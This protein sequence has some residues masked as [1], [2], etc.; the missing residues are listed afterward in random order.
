MLP[1]G[2]EGA[3]RAAAR[4]PATRSRRRRSL[5]LP[6]MPASQPPH[7]SFF[8]VTK[9][10]LLTRTPESECV[11]Y[12]CGHGDAW[13]GAREYACCIL[14]NEWDTCAVSHVC[15]GRM[16]QG[17]A[18]AGSHLIL[19]PPLE[20]LCGG[21]P[22]CS[23]PPIAHLILRHGTTELGFANDTSRCAAPVRTLLGAELHDSASSSSSRDALR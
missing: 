5:L 13:L 7:A 3:R 1:V 17:S 14:T 15:R 23:Y 18:V 16:L 20:Q 8:D 6:A 21:A 2:R 22:K 9:S 12:A 4:R 10:T 11:D 19:L